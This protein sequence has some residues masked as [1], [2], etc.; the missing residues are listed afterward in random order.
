MDLERSRAVSCH[1]TTTAMYL[2][3]QAI[4]CPVNNDEQVQINDIMSGIHAQRIREPRIQE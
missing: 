3:R 4:G 1:E 2:Q